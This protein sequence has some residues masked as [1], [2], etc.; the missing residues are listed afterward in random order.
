M[1]SVLFKFTLIFICFPLLILSSYCEAFID[2]VQQRIKNGD[3][4]NLSKEEE[5]FVLLSSYGKDM[6]YFGNKKTCDKLPYMKY[7]TAVSHFQP[8]GYKTTQQGHGVCLPKQCNT[9]FNINNQRLIQKLFKLKNWSL[10]KDAKLSLYDATKSMHPKTKVYSLAC[11]LFVSLVVLTVGSTVISYLF[12]NKKNIIQLPLKSGIIAVENKISKICCLYESFDLRRNL[13]SLYQTA[14]DQKLNE[15]IAIFNFLRVV[16]SLWVIYYHSYFIFSMTTKDYN[17]TWLDFKADRS[18]SAFWFAA[19]MSVEYFFVMTGFFSAYTLVPKLSKARLTLCSYF[20]II[21]HRFIRVWPALMLGFLFWWQIMPRMFTGPMWFVYEYK[22]SYCNDLW[23]SKFL[24]IENITNYYTYD[25]VGNYCM[26]ITWYIPTE[27]QIYLVAILA[28]ALYSRNR[29]AG[30][31]LILAL[32]F[33]SLFMGISNLI[34]QRIFYP[35]KNDNGLWHYFRMTPFTRWYTLFIGVI[36]GLLYY[37]YTKLQKKNIFHIFETKPLVSYFSM[38]SGL[39]LTF[40][41][42]FHKVTPYSLKFRMAW[43]PLRV[44][45][46]SLGMTMIFM[47]LASNRQFYLKSFLNL[48]IFQIMGKY[49][50]MTYLFADSFV[51]VMALINPVTLP[52]YSGYELV[53][54]TFKV[55]LVS[56]PVAIAAHLMI[57]KPL[58]NLESSFS[59]GGRQQTRNYIPLPIEKAKEIEL[60]IQA[61]EN[62]D[63]HC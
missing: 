8:P 23:W 46:I 34:N 41:V 17:K 49:S 5:A 60:S 32:I 47:P 58:M 35:T 16:T 18:L 43:Y 42:I 7:F 33:Q 31:A 4:R 26:V 50:Y 53:K 15:N 61:T 39:A 51:Y 57:E 55:F 27:F 24:M 12:R 45:L 62:S 38:I 25:E 20:N 13:R 40:F 2:K 1:R 28:L 52:G 11:F 37:E 56:Q 63:K 19:D 6:P 10:A 9:S 30:Y 44:L 21:K 54:F 59:G 22:V 48:R 14:K 29:K 36:W 3:N